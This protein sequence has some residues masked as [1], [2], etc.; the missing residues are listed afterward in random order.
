M[1]PTAVLTTHALIAI[2]YA[3]PLLFSPG[4]FLWLYGADTDLEARYLAR[5]LG[6]SL[7]AVSAI[8]WL[9]RDAPEGPALDAICF[10]LAIGSGL[11]VLVALIHQLTAPTAGALGWSTILICGALSAAYALLWLG[12]A[13]RRAGPQAVVAGRS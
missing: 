11:A 2:G 8:T 6:A 9:A 5:L 3:I 12:R 4:D 7:V 1:K 13:A 10:G